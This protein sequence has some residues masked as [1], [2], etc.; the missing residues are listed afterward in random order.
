MRTTKTEEDE[1]GGRK[2][3]PVLYHGGKFD[4]TISAHQYIQKLNDYIDVQ[5]RRLSATASFYTNSSILYTLTNEHCD[6]IQ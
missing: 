1:R 5:V 3:T 2:P 4:V 6:Y